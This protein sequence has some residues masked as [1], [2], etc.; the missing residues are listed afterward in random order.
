VLGVVS[1]ARAEAMLREWVNTDLTEL[2]EDAKAWERLFR[3]YPEIPSVPTKDILP[4][5]EASWRSSAWDRFHQQMEMA[6][7]VAER[8]RNTWDAPDLRQFDWYAWKA[9]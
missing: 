5:N 3:L 4:L 2:P 8:L 6:S 9:Q 7:G 1:V